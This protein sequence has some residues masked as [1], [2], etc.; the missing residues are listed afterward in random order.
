M[1]NCEQLI[2]IWIV[3]AATDEGKGWITEIWAYHHSTRA[4]TPEEHQVGIVLTAI[5]FNLDMDDMAVPI[6]QWPITSVS[7]S[8]KEKGLGLIPFCRRITK[9]KRLKDIILDVD[10]PTLALYSTLF[11][12]HWIRRPFSIPYNV[13]ILH[14][15]LSM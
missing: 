15:Y 8:T 2:R 7:H 13:M 6:A 4:I 11:L 14:C 12:S 3:R 5:T 10:T 1:C 9:G